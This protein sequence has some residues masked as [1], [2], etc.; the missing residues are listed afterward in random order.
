MSMYMSSCIVCL[1]TLSILLSAFG[2]DD[3]RR[4]VF[5]DKL[6]ELVSRII[7]HA[8]IDAAVDQVSMYIMFFWE[9]VMGYLCKLLTSRLDSSLFLSITNWATGW[10]RP[11]WVAQQLSSWWREREWSQA[12]W[13]VGE[14]THVPHSLFS[15]CLVNRRNLPLSSLYEF[16]N[17]V[18]L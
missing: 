4:K 10:L 15:K 11:S 17:T 9:Q 12:W 5:M 8:P 7:L 6:W 16:I 2:K 18:K 1:I 14:L 3:P 13:Y